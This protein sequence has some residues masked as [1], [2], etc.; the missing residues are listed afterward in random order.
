MIEEQR[1]DSVGRRDGGKEEGN[2]EVARVI[3][4][5]KEGCNLVT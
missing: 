1:D 4:V 3:K 5:G 2:R